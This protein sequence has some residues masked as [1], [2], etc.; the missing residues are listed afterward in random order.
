MQAVT[1]LAQ[2]QA[3]STRLNA[4]ATADGLRQVAKAIEVDGGHEAMVQRLAERC[5]LAR[6]VSA[7]TCPHALQHACLRRIY[8]SQYVFSSSCVA[9]RYVGELAEMAKSSSMVIVPEKPTDLSGV[10][11]SAMGIYEQAKQK[12]AK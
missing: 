12:A 8:A 4:A 3:E 6:F 10:I 11:A 7:A 1:L 5:V 2:A 9:G